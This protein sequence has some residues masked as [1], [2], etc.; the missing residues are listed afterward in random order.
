M[1][2]IIII[3]LLALIVVGY[4]IYL[5]NNPRN[6]K[7]PAVKKDEIFKQYKKELKTILQQC[8]GDND[9]KIQQK[10]LFL[11][12]CSSELSRNIFFTQS[13]SKKII[14]DLATL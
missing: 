3:L 8:N 12:K 4:L 13:E 10:K 1:D 9:L 2:I 11:Q 14:Q 7:S 6:T 5:N